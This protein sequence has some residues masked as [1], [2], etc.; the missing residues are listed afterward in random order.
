MVVSCV[1][2]VKYINWKGLKEIPRQDSDNK[3]GI[4]VGYSPIVEIVRTSM[5]RTRNL[6]N[7]CNV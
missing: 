3:D 2:L 6:S 4:I 1:N 7:E 5:V